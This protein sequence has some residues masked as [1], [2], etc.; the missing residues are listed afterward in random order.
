MTIVTR[1]EAYDTF[2]SVLG[3]V[4]LAGGQWLDQRFGGD[5]QF[6]GRKTWPLPQKAGWITRLMVSYTTSTSATSST[7]EFIYSELQGSIDN[8]QKYFNKTPH[9]LSSGPAADLDTARAQVA[10]EVGYRLGFTVN[11]RGPIMYNWV[12][13]ADAADPQ[14]PYYIPEGPVNDPLMTLPRYWP[15]QVLAQL[16]TIRSDGQRSRRLRRAEQ[17]D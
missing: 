6:L 13:Q 16:D 5:D 9:C 12:P 2:S 8:L 7:D 15:T 11:P 17:S 14:R 4:G 3:A 10:R 1:A